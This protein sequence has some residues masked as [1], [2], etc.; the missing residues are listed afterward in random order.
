MRKLFR[1]SV[2]LPLSAG[3]LLTILFFSGTGKVYEVTSTDKYCMSCHVHT[4]ADMAWKWS[5]HSSNM[6]GMNVHCV[7]CHLPPKDKILKYSLHK[8]KHGF[9]DIYGLYFKD[10]TDID[11]VI[12]KTPEVASGFVYKESCLKCHTNL[13]PLP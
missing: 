9:K 1:S 11:W 2:L 4:S 7:D 5:T 8:A 3:I 6:A 13:F 10:S 12:K